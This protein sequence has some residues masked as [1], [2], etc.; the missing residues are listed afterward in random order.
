[1]YRK[2]EKR[3]ENGKT[4]FYSF[5]FDKR[6]PFLS[7]KMKESHIFSKANLILNSF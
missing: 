6:N 4:V 2:T 5:V 7:L 1:M 3:K